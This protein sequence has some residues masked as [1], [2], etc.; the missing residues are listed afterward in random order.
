VPA[1]RALAVLVT[2]IAAC[3]ARTV[4]RDRTTAALYRD[5]QREVT[6]AETAGWSIDRI[7]LEEALPAALDSVCRVDPL[8][9]RSLLTWLD[10]EIHRLGGP[11]EEAYVARGR[12][13]SA[14]D[15]LLEVTRIRMVLKRA[16]DVAPIDCPFWLDIE[17]PFEGRQIGDDRWQL[18]LGG[19]GKAIAMRQDRRTDL[20]FGG[21]GRLLI[22]RG[23]GSRSG[24]YSGLEIGASASFPKDSLGQRGPLLIAIDVVAPIVYR[25]TLVNGYAEVEGGW[26]GHTNEDAL[27]T[28]DHGVHVGASI[29]LRALRTRFFF[30]GVAFGVSYERT[31]VAGDDL[32]MVKVGIRIVFDANL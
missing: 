29:G 20:S 8:A 23:F 7:E 26:L 10:E 1:A 27:G 19:G 16:D 5:L 30:P 15:E 25:Y 24:L 17:D 32:T 6:T 31:L 4:P 28:V 11:V 21:A 2:M 13:L 22:G 9:R 3:G 18:T 12:R 14:V